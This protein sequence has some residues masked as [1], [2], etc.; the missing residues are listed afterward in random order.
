MSGDRIA[1]RIAV[2]GMACRYPDAR[3]PEQLWQ[4]VLGR[5]RAFRRLPEVRLSGGYRGA[6][7]DADRTYLTHAAVLRDWE[8]DRRRFGI[9]GPLYRAADQ[10]H[11]LALETAA[12]ALADAGHPGGA[13]LDRDLTGVVL[14]NSLTGEFTR[15]ATLRFRWP[16][17]ADA[18]ATALAEAGLGPGPA[19]A[20]LARLESLVKEPFPVP[21]EETLTGALANTIAG[22]ICNQFDFHGTG[23]T[24]DG[25]CS[26]S[27][28]AVSTACRALAEGDCDF[29]LAGGVDMSLDPLEL[30]G[31]ARLGALATTE[32]RVYDERPTGFLPGEGCGVVALMRAEDADRLGRRSYAH[33]IGWA[34]SSDG[35]GGLSRPERRGQVLALGRAYRRAGIPPGA[36]GLIEGHGT[37]TVI[38]DRVELA[39]LNEVRGP[40]APAA[41]GTI[42][43]NIGHTKAAAGVAGLIKAVLAVRHRVLP[44]TTGC[45]RPHELVRRGPLR[46]LAEPEPWSAP[47]PRAGV[48][49]MGFGGINAHVIVEGARGETP[50]VLPASVRRWSA[51]IG[52]DEIVYLA[53]G[54]PRALA[55]RLAELA[56]SAV[57]L[58]AAE[59]GDVAATAWRSGGAGGDGAERFRA[60]VVARSPEELAGAADAAA[61]AATRWAGGLR[62]VERAG[63]A[64]GSGAAPRVGLLFPGQAAPVRAAVPPWAARLSLPGLPGSA[65]P[66]I[67]GTEVAQPAVVWQSL[68]ALA[69]LRELGV[70]AVAACGHSLGELTALH[71]AG[72][73]SA[74]E[75]LELAARRGR[76]MAEHGAA[77]TTMA[78]VAAGADAVARLVSGTE[79]VIAG[80]NAPERI[81]VSGPRR[82]IAVV[83]DRA[84]RAGF[85]V[86]ELPVSHGF[87][88]PA[89]RSARR[90]LREAV[91]LLRAPEKVVISTITGKE[92]SSTSDGL[93]ELLVDQL[94]GP[95]LFTDAVAELARRCELM[96]E[97]G[98]GTILSALAGANGLATPSVSLDCGGD[99]RRH[100]FATAVLAA[101]GAAKL[102][103]WFSG[104]ASRELAFDARPRFVVNPC[105]ERDGWASAPVVPSSPPPSAPRV[106][107]DAHGDPLAVLT[108]HL[109]ATLELPADAITPGSSLLGDLHLN[110]LQLVQLIGTVAEALGRQPADMPP[111]LAGATVAEA[112]ATLSALP[113][114]ERGS[115]GGPVRGVR[116]WVRPFEQRWVPFRPGDR[117]SARWTV[118]A[119]PG[120]WLHELAAPADHTGFAVALTASAGPAELAELLREIAAAA[121]RRL[122]VVHTGHPAAAAV[123]RSVAVELDSCAVAVVEVPDR[124]RR[125]DPEVLSGQT[126]YLELRCAPDG[127]LWRAV[128]VPRAP[129]ERAGSPGA[130]G[131]PLG[132]GDVCLVTGGVRGITAYLAAELAERTGCTL[133]LTGRTPADDPGVAAA[134]AQ[135]RAR[136][137]AHYESGD[138]GDFG[139]AA[140]LVAAARKHGPLRGLLHGAGVNRPRRIGAVTAESLAETMHPKVF[141]LRALLGQA[142][143]GLALVLGF[144]SIIG[145][146]G[147]AGQAEY[148]V[149]ND[150]LRVEL[151][152]WSA[153]HPACRTHALEWSVWSGLG[154][155]VRMEVLDELRRRGIT[156]VEPELGAR[157]LFSLLAD[158]D[159]PVTVLLTS[160]FPSAPTLDAG[161]PA[162]WPRFAERVPVCFPGV[163]AVFEADLSLGADPYLADHRV[164]GVPVLPAVLGLEAMT[165]AAAL[166]GGPGLPVSVT[167]AGFRAPVTVDRAA[168]RAIRVAALAE[169]GGVDTVLADDTVR[170]LARIEPAGE[171]PPTLKPTFVPDSESGVSDWYGN[172]FFHEGRFRRVTGYAEL[173][174]FR[175]SARLTPSTA[176]SWFSPF[177][178]AELILGDPGAHDA[179]IHAL[180]ACVP[181]RRV[182]PVGVERFTVWRQPSGPLLVHAREVAHTA[183][184]YEF[185]VDLLAADGAAVARWQGLRLRAVGPLDWPDGLPARLVGP[186]LS[187]GLIEFGIAG[188]VAVS[189]TLAAGTLTA[190]VLGEPPATV[191]SGRETGRETGTAT[192]AEVDVEDGESGQGSGQDAADEIVVERSGALTVVRASTRVLESASRVHLTLTIRSR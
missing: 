152:R 101:A 99:P 109:A 104:R 50:P 58:S 103:A 173:S 83:A 31:F 143:D 80:Y 100:A 112:A 30:V 45:V 191:N 18:A 97:A 51:R 157:A 136:V 34:S 35:S 62:L 125:V 42:K 40:G 81:V 74:A 61:E 159:A 160:R 132:P 184:D 67:G 84:R 187:R 135:L 94:T 188:P 156:P 56:A 144:G 32:M 128:V 141:G 15:A 171:P 95:V 127:S 10:A 149:A 115:S 25:A 27:L 182:L 190:T 64:L 93:V 16:F 192:S 20:V 185:D 57:H 88:S 116:D 107:V 22:R 1:V 4:N 131:L 70:A 98:P 8:F 106:P 7:G 69:W 155:G 77:D 145:R 168:G 120:H 105:E 52:P 175:V 78:S 179:T 96:V 174:A 108:G 91:G 11:W 79:V 181:H 29:M 114:A 172:L 6:R 119:E 189:T 53:A 117:V 3:S 130:S 14:G 60:V 148:C 75:V 147:L 102:D 142:G 86:A 161:E 72:A 110:S 54:D 44:P 126:R 169:P 150:W 23:Y 47:V 41:L 111:S 76:I 2:V 12:D 39:A 139:D 140:A 154:M 59:V 124:H 17:L 38:G 176:D 26:S 162:S 129:V 28:L 183:D 92:L 163:E 21:G 134:L 89:M 118:R 87:H 68:A 166:A 73:C 177:H 133:V 138:V 167:G 85:A 146:Q 82:E 170:F 63:F 24:V 55:R 90:P 186:W 66:G 46:V 165:Q 49:A 123:G 65:V 71:W 33:I 5:R 36:V 178:S 113:V 151:E 137:R 48:S 121:P 153:E 13:G 43:A 180:Q 37:G 158:P 9:P 19:G 122:L 164:D